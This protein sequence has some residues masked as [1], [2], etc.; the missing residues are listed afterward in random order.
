T[1]LAV[2]RRDIRERGG[3][4]QVLR[5]DVPGKIWKAT[6][7]TGNYQRLHLALQIVGSAFAILRPRIEQ[8][9]YL[10]CPALLQPLDLDV[11][12][13]L[14]DPFSRSWLARSQEDLGHGLGEHRLCF[15]SITGLD[16]T[17]ALEAEH[18][19]EIGFASFSDGRRKLRQPL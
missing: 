12:N 3:D 2:F 1:R 9:W 17:P 8:S 7:D 6:D 19:P 4:N 11:A 15:V 16:L 18:E 10:I 14:A 13:A 5:L